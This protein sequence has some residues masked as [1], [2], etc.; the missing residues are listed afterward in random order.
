MRM[1]LSA[2]T[3]P[4]ST[5]T[6]NASM[7]GTSPSGDNGEI[8]QLGGEA[9]AMEEA[10]HQH[11]G[12]G[13]RLHAEPGLKRTEIIERFVDHREADDGVDQKGVDFE[14]RSARQTTA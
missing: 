11:R 1:A 10:E 3:W 14:S 5:P 13:I 7:L 8:L 12:L 9:E 2:S 6:L 4:I